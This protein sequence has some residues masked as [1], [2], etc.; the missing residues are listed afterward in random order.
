MPGPISTMLSSGPGSMA[1][2]IPSMTPSSCRKCWPK[3]LR[4]LC[5]MAGSAAPVVRR[6]ETVL[7]V[8]F[9]TQ[10]AKPVFKCGFNTTLEQDFACPH[11]LELV[12]HVARRSEEHTSELQSRENLVCRLLLEQNTSTARGRTCRSPATGPSRD[13]R[14]PG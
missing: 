5:A 9:A 13:R 8:G 2:T 10:L 3:R 7:N 4:A 11:A 1:R 12:F 14:W 6:V